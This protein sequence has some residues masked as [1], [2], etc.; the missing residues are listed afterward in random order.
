M[1]PPPGALLAEPCGGVQEGLAQAE[2][3]PSGL[4]YD[5]KTIVAASSPPSAASTSSAG[6]ARG[7][8]VMAA[9]LSFWGLWSPPGCLCGDGSADA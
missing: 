4:S 1:P 8:L 6:C 2:P 5:Y 7:L 3:A 9:G